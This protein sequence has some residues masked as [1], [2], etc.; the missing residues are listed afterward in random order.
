MCHV[1][2][3]ALCLQSYAPSAVRA[4]ATSVNPTDTMN[5]HGP[6]LP[7]YIYTLN[8]ISLYVALKQ[9]S[10]KHLGEWD[11]DV[12]FIHGHFFLHLHAM[13]RSGVV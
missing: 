6:G 4:S 2:L 9:H 8:T 12:L 3:L 7:Q 5:A 13:C 10:L 1:V 11:M